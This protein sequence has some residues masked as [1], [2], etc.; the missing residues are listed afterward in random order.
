MTTG[1]VLAL[2]AIALALIMTAAWQTQR[3]TGNDGWADVF[4]SFGTGFAGILAL[5]LSSEMM[6]PARKYLVALLLGAWSVRLGLHILLR[7]LKSQDDPRYAK[8]RQKWRASADSRMF[9]FLQSQAF[10]GI[11][12][13]ICVYIAAA[14]P[15][16][17]LD[18]LD[19]VGTAVMVVALAGETIADY[20]LKRFSGDAA[21][22]GRICDTGLWGWSRHPNY[23]FE[24]LGWIS[25]GLIAADFDGDY[26][27]GWLALAAPLLMYFLLR[28]VSGVPP[29]EE[30]MRATRGRAF[31]DYQ[32][33][34]NIFFPAPPRLTSGQ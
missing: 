4:W 20:Q 34:T 13:V 8:L 28:H 1:L 17:E 14:R 22:R 5:L 30:H 25:Y 31:R 19:C 32:D 3:M 18:L 21:N 16:V 33:R 12:L 26:F 6:S 2:S 24:W 23:F 9:F 10:A 7:T 27:Y 11:V 15:D 29:L